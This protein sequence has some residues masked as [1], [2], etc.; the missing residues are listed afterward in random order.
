M[1]LILESILGVVVQPLSHVQLFATLWI[2]ACQASLSITKF[3]SIELMMPSNDLSLCHHH[4]FSSCPQSFPTSGS[5]PMNQ[6][7]TS[8]GQSIGVS[9][10]ASV[11]PM[12]FL[13]WFPLGLTGLISLLSRELSRIF[14]S[15]VVQS[16]DSSVLSLLHGATLTSIHHYWKNHS[17]D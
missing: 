7:F 8:G 2:A 15:T 16:I 13:G 3:M 17:F 4:L 6:F 14:S 5:F 9:A 10:S 11:L 1:V 12:N